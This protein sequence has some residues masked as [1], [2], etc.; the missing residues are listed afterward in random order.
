MKNVTTKFSENKIQI[1]PRLLIEL[2]FMFILWRIKFFA[3]GHKTTSNPNY[4]HQKLE[5]C[6]S[7]PIEKVV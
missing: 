5:E 2:F 4:P 7:N 6:D 3:S 1:L